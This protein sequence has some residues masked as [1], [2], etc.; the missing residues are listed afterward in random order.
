MA[1]YGDIHTG[2]HCVFILH[3][4]LVFITK[5]RHPVFTSRHLERI[6][7]VMR[8]VC[9]DFGTDLEEFHG[10]ASTSTCW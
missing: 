2:R 9:A 1:E 10:Q 4:H 8:D 6:E 3:T 5:Y 7:Q